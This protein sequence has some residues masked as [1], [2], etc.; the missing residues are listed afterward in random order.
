MKKR[1]SNTQ[2]FTLVEL[3]VVMVIIAI[4]AM[5]II[6]R[7]GVFREGAEVSTCQANQRVLT[8][9]AALWVAENPATNRFANCDI[10][11]H[12]I[13][14]YI[15]AS[16]LQCPTTGNYSSYTTDSDGRWTCSQSTS[17]GRPHARVFSTSS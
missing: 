15:G 7:L 17:S 5:I 3:I 8:S 16:D 11:T 9:V 1:L 10:G 14:D 12:L 4:L 2:G 13:P 6:P